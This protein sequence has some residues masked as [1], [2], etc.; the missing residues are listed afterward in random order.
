MGSEGGT[1]RIY[2]GDQPGAEMGFDELAARWDG[3][4]LLVSDS[5]ISRTRIWVAALCPFLLYGGMAAF[6]LGL[7][8]RVERHWAVTQG[9]ASWAGS[10]RTSIGQ[11]AGLLVIALAAGAGYRAGSD[12]G[13]LSSPVAIAAI[14]DSHLGSF[15]PKVKTEEVARLLDTPG[16]A[17]V[18]ARIPD[19]YKAGHLRGAINIP[20][21]SSPEQCQEAM[22]HVPKNNRIL[23]YSHSNGCPYGAI[24]SRELIALGY[25]NILIHR[26]GWV[27]WEKHHPLP[28]KSEQFVGGD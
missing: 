24:V 3:T 8:S 26:G 12:A 2:D 13:F 18:D 15:L 11:A 25:H 19:D 22:A 17:V 9:K 1:A 21:S 14:Q 23:V 28:A 20:V 27:E 5:P 6:G 16:I 7:L 10:F 4:G